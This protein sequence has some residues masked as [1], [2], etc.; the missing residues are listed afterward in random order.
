MLTTDWGVVIIVLVIVLGGWVISSGEVTGGVLV[1]LIGCGLFVPLYFNAKLTLSPLCVNDD[2]ITVTTFGCTW[3]SMKWRDV[4]EVR[5]SQ[6]ADVGVSKPTRK[7]FI[8]S[9]SGER[10]Y[11]KQ[12]GPII[13]NETIIDVESLL[14]ILRQKSR[15]YG[16][17]IASLEG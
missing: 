12:S 6:W 9:T 4:K 10:F 17:A 15:Q 11:L 13:F 1:I 8:Y 7:F 2:G 14:D 3:K 16:F 5:S